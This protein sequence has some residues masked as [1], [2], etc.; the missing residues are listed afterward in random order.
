M[1]S[2]DGCAHKI[3][4]RD[5]RVHCLD[6]SDY[7]LCIGC[8]LGEQFTGT[9]TTAHRTTVFRMSGDGRRH[10][11]VESSARIVY[12]DALQLQQT[13]IISAAVPAPTLPEPSLKAVTGGTTSDYAEAIG[14]YVR[15]SSAPEPA[16]STATIPHVEIAVDGWGPFFFEDMAPTPV[17]VHLMSAILAYLDTGKIGH[18]VPEAYSQFLD[19]QG[20]PRDCDAWK[21]NLNEKRGQKTEDVADAGLRR[22]FDLYGI[23]YILRP[24]ARG[25]NDNPNT[26][27][28]V[29]D[30]L[31]P[32]LTLKGFME[33][34]SIEML[35]DPNAE[36]GNISR[37]LR[38]WDLAAVRGWG[39]VPRSVLPEQ[40]DKRMEARVER[41]TTVSRERQTRQLEASR[42]KNMLQ[43][44][45]EQNSLDLLDD[46]RYYYTY[47]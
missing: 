39:D 33:I 5:P 43:A 12:P 28:S 10:A 47:R 38:S 21:S 19:D 11:A 7:D 26:E 13:T 46:R 41:A 8:A 3:S 34:T 17:F 20:Y 2:C 6:C 32:L 37:A 30:G 9:H 23:E 24:R 4:A 40:A 18:L 36:W 27:K 44:I 35:C 31:M 25:P 22:V 42:V 1:A 16:T 29:S 14:V 45:G 15:P